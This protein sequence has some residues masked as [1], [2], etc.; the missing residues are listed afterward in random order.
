MLGFLFGLLIVVVLI[1]LAIAY[2]PVRWILA[3]LAGL[4]I[5]GGLAL[6]LYLQKE[7]HDREAAKR[8]VSVSQ[9]QFEDLVLWNDKITGRVR[10]NSGYTVTS[11]ELELTLK[12]CVGD[13]PPHCDV[14]GQT[15]RS[16]YVSIPPGQVRGLDEY[17]SFSDVPALRGKRQWS[18]RVTE[19]SAR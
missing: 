9:L 7:E 11:I 19:I 5:L 3:G 2:R 13:S 14:V 10:N 8:R 6:A 12:D 18:Y 1:L 16:V 17:A 15:T 4:A